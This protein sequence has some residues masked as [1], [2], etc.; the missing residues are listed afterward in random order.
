MEVEAEVVSE[1]EAE[2]S[3]EA[4]IEVVIE[5]ETV[6]DGD[7]VNDGDVVS[8]DEVVSDDDAVIEGDA[9][10]EGEAVSE[11]VEEIVRA[12][13]NTLRGD[14]LS[15]VRGRSPDSRVAGFRRPSRLPSG[16]GCRSPLRSQLRGQSRIRP[17]LGRPHRV[18]C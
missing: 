4:V 15:P 7:V 14:Q 9:V 6:S 11:V 18:P 2:W 16:H 5:G 1:G 17:R 3:G 13:M 8:D 10:S 12:V